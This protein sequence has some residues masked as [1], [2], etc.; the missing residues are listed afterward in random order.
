VGLQGALV[1]D[2]VHATGGF[3]PSVDH[4]KVYD[5]VDIDIP[6]QSVLLTD[7]FQTNDP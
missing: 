5:V 6:D 7:Q 2:K 4:F 1:G 3:S